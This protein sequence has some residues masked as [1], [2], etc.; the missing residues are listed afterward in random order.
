MTTKSNCVFCKIIR[1]EIPSVKV[2]EDDQVL[3]FL[4]IRPIQPGH[5][6][7]IPKTHIDHFMDLPDGLAQH[8]VTVGQRLSRQ[9]RDV[10]KPERVGVVVNGY[11]V[12][13]AH[14]HLVPLEQPHDISSRAYAY[15]EG[16]QVVFNAEKSPIVSIEERTRIADLIKIV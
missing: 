12:S 2:Y 7:I 11:G 16:D 6:M 3:A 14:Y 13:H 8:I 1:G 9:I 10:L 15:V 4:D 5:T